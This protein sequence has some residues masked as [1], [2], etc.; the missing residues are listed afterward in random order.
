MRGKRPD[1]FTG[2]LAALTL[3]LVLSAVGTVRSTQAAVALEQAPRCGLA[4]HIH[5]A[6][7]YINDVLVCGQKAHTHSQNCYAVLLRDNDI[8]TLLTRIDETP[9][10]SLESV[11]SGDAAMI[12]QP[13][14]TA[15]SAATGAEAPLSSA[16][17]FNEGLHIE[18]P[19]A[20][21]DSR[22]P[23]AIQAQQ[24]AAQAI[25]AVPDIS[26]NHVNFYIRLDGALTCIGS[27]RLTGTYSHPNAC[28]YYQMSPSAAVSAYTSAVE[29]GLTTASLENVYTLRYNTDHT[30]SFSNEAYISGSSVR[31]LSFGSGSSD[32][33][34]AR[35]ALLYNGSAPVDF[36]TLTLDYSAAGSADGVRYVEK[37]HAYALPA[38]SGYH[39]EDADGS[40]ITSITLTAPAAVYA[41]PDTYTVYY[42]ANGLELFQDSGLQS[43]TL[44]TLRDVPEG[45]ARWRSSETTYTGGQQIT[46][47][48]NLTLTAVRY[49]TVT[50]RQL[51]GSSATQQVLQGDSVVLPSGGYWT[52]ESGA[53]LSGGS[54]VTFWDDAV[55]TAVSGPPL[56][57]TYN[58]N[59]STPKEVFEPAVLPTL[60]G[61]SSIAVGE[62]ESLTVSRVSQRVV[63]CPFR[64][65][66]VRYG[67]V[68]FTG[69]QTETGELLQPSSRIGWEE[70]ASYDADG[71]GVVSL[72]GV[73]RYHQLQSVN[74]FVKYNSKDILVD[75]DKEYYTD[76]IFSTFVGGIDS[77]VSQW[78]DYLNRKYAV[79]L[80]RSN[81]YLT[82][83]KEVRK[84]Y[85]GSTVPWLAEFPEDAYI[86]EELKKYAVNGQLS[87][88]NDVGE[89]EPV[90]VEDLSEEGYAIRWYMFFVSTDSGYRDWHI[91]GALVRKEGKAHVAK[92]F[93]GNETLISASRE[94]F[95][96]HASNAK[97]TKQYILTTSPVSDARKAEILAE[98]G[99]DAAKIK[100]WITPMDDGD[101][102]ADTMLWEFGDMDYG[103]V[104]TVTEH[105][106]EL[107][108]TVSRAEWSVADASGLNASA[109]GS[110]HTVTIRG[111]TQATDLEEPDWPQISFNNIYFRS[112]SLMLKK[113]DAATGHALAGAEFQFYQNDRLM[114]FDYD[115][116][117][118]LY[119]YNRN[120]SGAVTALTCGGY[121]NVS[122][123]GFSYSEG[124]ITIREVT[125][126]TGYN[127]VGDVTLGYTADSDGDGVPDSAV[128]ITSSSGAFARY[129]SG[130][131]VIENSSDPIDVTVT[132]EWNCADS[133]RADVVMQLLANGSAT[134]A[135]S[136]LQDSGQSV[137]VTLTEAYGWSHT[138][139]SLPV[140]ASGGPVTW[141]VREIKI[142]SENCKADYTFPNWIASYRTET[143]GLDR[144]SLVVENTPKRPMLYLEKRDITGRKLLEGAEFTLVAVDEDGAPLPGAVT[145]TGVTGADGVLSFDNLRYNT[146]Y[147]LT[148]TA[149]PANYLPFT[150][151]A[152]LTIAENGTVEVET[153][154]YVSSA[155]TAYHI[156]AL[157]RG[158]YSLPESGGPG[159]LPF[160][161]LGAVLTAGAL[162]GLV[163]LGKE[164]RRKG[165]SRP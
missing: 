88:P 79:N 119:V 127:R 114:T 30:D 95:Y 48:G 90:N 80:D 132:K 159:A 165:G 69:W 84:L 51:D 82:Y 63:S 128:G 140:Y 12:S 155:G 67:A 81:D 57:V 148:E 99:L 70:L 153:H 40:S 100:A 125:V 92:T 121:T 64:M 1:K 2:I 75:K 141:S 154:G 105:P 41:R 26:S 94:K 73:W 3:L 65:S 89:T 76:V 83:D 102:D 150:E 55:F 16:L 42:E 74:F 46:V 156:R 56:T 161:V 145:K 130:L 129:D 45:Y 77:E 62:G 162:C 143:T 157:N 115:D 24:A 17:V 36:Y 14:T 20:D 137:T 7:C 25:D 103:E 18:A 133:E 15:P 28:Y 120:G 13:Q 52:D 59:W 34:A 111:V 109:S 107:E 71:D 87:V 138:W 9:D 86:F 10:K 134:T 116:A 37:N 33:A 135:A 146:R 54:A 112:D 58:I 11:I 147:R 122:T 66:Y 117:A 126:P 5:T 53:S 68:Y 8:N 49:V 39:W 29:T 142:G 123:T 35:Y 4:E 96:I 104:W 98:L 163:L 78:A 110:G 6:D 23:A 43:G 85:G 22:L 151:P 61:S 152:Y 101:T 136:I 60:V 131:L 93:A 97:G 113:E 38:L 32:Q 27:R 164:N 118:G 108:D 124:D 50:F 72:T 144:L 19:A 91:D 158:A 139:K 106:P 21:T 149:A 160:R 47:S 44:Y 31:S